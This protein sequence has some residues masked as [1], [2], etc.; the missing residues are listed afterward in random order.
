M[1]DQYV[2]DINDF[3]KYSILRAFQRESGLP[4]IICWMLTS[5]DGTGEGAHIDY[6]AQPT[7]FR[8]FDPEVFDGLKSVIFTGQRS[9]EAIEAS[10]ILKTSKFVRSGLNDE[11]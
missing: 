9:I 2:G 8:D 1:K 3:Y 5:P 10:G 7:R 6:L 4:L 11:I